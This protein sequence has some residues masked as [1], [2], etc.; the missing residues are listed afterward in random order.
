MTAGERRARL[1]R[2]RFAE[3]LAAAALMAKG[4]ASS[5]AT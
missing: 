3:V 5:A 4:I 2:G 1:R